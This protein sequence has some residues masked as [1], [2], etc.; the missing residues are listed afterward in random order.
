MREENRSL[1]ER[2]TSL[3]SQGAVDISSQE[4]SDATSVK[5]D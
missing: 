5:V 1:E 3:D 4:N 2:L